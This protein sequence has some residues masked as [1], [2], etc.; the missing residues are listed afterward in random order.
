M[1]EHGPVQSVDR[2]FELMERLCGSRDGLTLHALSEQSRLHKST[3]HRLLAALG[4][5]GYVRKDEESGGTG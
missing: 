4:A 5:R 3:V 2:A 1:E